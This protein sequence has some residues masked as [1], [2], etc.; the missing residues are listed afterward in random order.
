MKR[1]ALLTLLCAMDT[2][3]AGQPGLVVLE[4]Q[5]RGI[6][7]KTVLRQLWDRTWEVA[8]SFPGADA[9]PADETRRRIFDQN[10]LLPVRCDEACY[11]RVALKLQAS[12]ILVPSVEKTGDQLKFN[13]L[14]VQGES[15]K[16]LQE[17]SVWSD[18]RVDRA[19][20]A[21]LSKVMNDAGSNE[22]IEVPSALWTTL[23]VGAAGLAGALWFGLSQDRTRT[24]ATKATCVPPCVVF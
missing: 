5:S 18:G 9:V 7:D 12:R 20:A 11:Q 3:H 13:F 24:V 16:K 21:G 2:L 10:V 14:L 22:A 15:G 6:L 8:S 4:F 17:A 19:L 1:I 23:G